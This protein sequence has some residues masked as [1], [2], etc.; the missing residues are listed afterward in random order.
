M[1]RFATSLLLVVGLYAPFEL[2]RL[3]IRH[4]NVY[5]DLTLIPG[6]VFEIAVLTAGV[7]GT[8]YAWLYV[9]PKR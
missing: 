8:I 6:F 7:I 4:H 1:K 5:D 2:G 9:V 3:I